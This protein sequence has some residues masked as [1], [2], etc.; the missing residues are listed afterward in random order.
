MHGG[1]GVLKQSVTLKIWL[2]FLNKRCNFCPLCP[3][4]TY[5][6]VQWTPENGEDVWIRVHRGSGPTDT[7]CP[8]NVYI[9]C[10]YFAQ[11]AHFIVHNV[12]PIMKRLLVNLAIL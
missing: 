5:R 3:C 10:K 8:F 4:W 11:F 12:H 7:M 2:K 1:P 9:Q 6:P